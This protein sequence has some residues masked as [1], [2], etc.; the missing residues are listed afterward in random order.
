MADPRVQA[1][2]KE[3]VNTI[4]LRDFLEP[5]LTTAC[6]TYDILM[7]LYKPRYMWYKID[8]RKL[9]NIVAIAENIDELLVLLQMSGIKI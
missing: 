7:L 4:I 8:A 9:M 5:K 2:Q 3:L 6:N 1:L